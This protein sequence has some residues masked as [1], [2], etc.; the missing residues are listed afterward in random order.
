MSLKWARRVAW[1]SFKDL[2]NSEKVGV[3]DGCFVKLLQLELYLFLKL[4]ENR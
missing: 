2:I 4:F 3:F 1:M